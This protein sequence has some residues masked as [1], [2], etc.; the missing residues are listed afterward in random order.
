MRQLLPKRVVKRHIK[1]FKIAQISRDDRQFMRNCTGC[2]HGIFVNGIRLPV[3]QPRPDSKSYR[4]H[5]QYIVCGC[6]LISPRLNFRSLDR[7]LLTRQFNANLY[8]TQR[9]RTEIKIG[10][11]AIDSS[12]AT[13]A[14]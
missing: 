2:N 9:Y 13:T 3:H 7:I 10:I 11:S 8:F 12:H 14:P 1:A 5:R 6:D 4:I